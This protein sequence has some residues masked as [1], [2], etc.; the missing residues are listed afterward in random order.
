M[1]YIGWTPSKKLLSLQSR[2][3]D[4]VSDQSEVFQRTEEHEVKREIAHTDDVIRSARSVR[5]ANGLLTTAR[6]RW[7][8]SNLVNSCEAKRV[9]GGRRVCRGREMR[10]DSDLEHCFMITTRWPFAFPL[11]SKNVIKG[12]HKSGTT[13]TNHAYQVAYFYPAQ[14]AASHFLSLSILSLISIRMKK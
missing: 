8:L 14:P 3:F 1:R 10:S 5:G 12:N 7:K 13:R 11:H 2:A 6:W 4:E 9:K